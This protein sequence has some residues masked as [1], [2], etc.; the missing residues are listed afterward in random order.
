MPKEPTKPAKKRGPPAFQV[1]FANVSAGDA[2]QG[3]KKRSERE[4]TTIP[5]RSLASDIQ[6]KELWLTPEQRSAIDTL[7]ASDAGL[8]TKFYVNGDQEQQSQYEAAA[9]MASH[10]LDLDSREDNGNRWSVKWS[11]SKDGGKT[12]RVLLQWCV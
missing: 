2:A 4:N 5:A 3:L 12:K 7:N 10:G 11:T 9:L 8:D 1:R 6:L